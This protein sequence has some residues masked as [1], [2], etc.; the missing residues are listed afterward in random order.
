MREDIKLMAEF[1]RFYQANILKPFVGNV[2]KLISSTGFQNYAVPKTFKERLTIEANK[3]AKSLESGFKEYF[4]KV[5]DKVY[6]V[7]YEELS[8]QLE[9]ALKFNKIKYKNT[10]YLFDDVKK[11]ILKKEGDRW[12]TLASTN[13]HA[14]FN[15]WKMYE[16]DG[17]KLSE[18]IWKMANEASKN[19]Q[20]QVVL[21][22]QTGMSADRLKNQI[23]KTAEQVEVKIPKYLEKQLKGATPEVMA[24]EIGKYIERRESYNAKRVARTEMQK[25]WRGSYMEQTKQLNFVKG[26]KWNLSASHR[27]KCICED[28]ANANMGMG[29]GVYPVNAV[30][31]GGLP[32]HPNCICYLTSI[33]KEN[34]VPL[35]G[36]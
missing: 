34:I 19:I 21:S 3:Y 33:L 30:P 8:S 22:L 15:I 1:E 35:K 16:T 23:L 29:A 6:E 12:L 17:L 20:R 10:E 11:R 9:E 2:E 27:E 7:W 13:K 32:P 36:R 14:T 5:D 24:K 28:Y 31:N 4:K 26:I 18:R 25:A